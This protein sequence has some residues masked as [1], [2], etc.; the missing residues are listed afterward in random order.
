MAGNDLIGAD[1]ELF[2]AVFERRLLLGSVTDA[3]ARSYG[4]R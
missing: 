2:L 3:A 4:G 1:D